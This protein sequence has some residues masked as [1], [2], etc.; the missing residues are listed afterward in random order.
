MRKKFALLSL[1]NIEP[2]L[3]M[4]LSLIM[5]THRARAGT[6]ARVPCGFPTMSAD[7][8]REQ[9]PC[10]IKGEPQGKGLGNLDGTLSNPPSF[11]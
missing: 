7:P 6:R 5:P 4:I 3:S 10:C 11:L 9:R 8:E 1:E 2:K